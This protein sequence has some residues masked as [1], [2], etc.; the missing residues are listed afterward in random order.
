[1]FCACFWAAMVVDQV[2]VVVVAQVLGHRSDMR[3]ARVF[4]KM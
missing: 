4:D 2:V 3:N 1:M